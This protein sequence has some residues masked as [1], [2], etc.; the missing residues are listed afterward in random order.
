MY[1]RFIADLSL[2]LAALLAAAGCGPASAAELL[3]ARHA[4]GSQTTV[5]GLSSGAFMAV[6]YAVAFSGT[7]KGV[8]S[9]AGGPYNCAN[10]EFGATDPCMTGRPSGALALQ[11]ARLLESAGQIDALSNVAKQRVYVFHGTRDRT[12]A[13]TVAAATRDFFLAAGVPAS[14]LAYVTR[15]PAGHSF[16]APTFGNDCGTSAAPFV[17]HCAPY[18]QPREILSQL[19]GSLNGPAIAL[20]GTVKPFDQREFAGAATSL[21]SVGFVY[22]PAA[23][24]SASSGDC[25]VHVVFHGCQQGAE[26]VGSDVYGSAGFNRWA[27]TNKII[28]LYPQIME[29]P[30]SPFNPLGCWDWWG[31]LYTGPTFMVRSGVQLSAVRSMV[32]R[33]TRP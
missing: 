12:V 31:T 28:V 3:P 23:C 33:L 27:D 5:S 17:E 1:C 30:V 7:V 25:S 6:Q 21:A 14:H 18:D 26:V 8:A 9:V 29:S 13:S 4:D 32:E 19:H 2:A 22:I 10:T 11:T 24:T 20:S 15:I 16:I